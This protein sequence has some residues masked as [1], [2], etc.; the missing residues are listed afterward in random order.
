[1]ITSASLRLCVSE[2]LHFR[3]S[4][5][6]SHLSHHIISASLHLCVSAS[7]RL[8]ISA[9]LHRCIS[10]SLDH[11]G[12]ISG[13]LGLRVALRND[14]KRPKHYEMQR[15]ASAEPLLVRLLSLICAE[16]NWLHTPVPRTL[17]TFFRFWSFWQ[18]LGSL[19]VGPLFGMEG[20]QV[21]RSFQNLAVTP[22]HPEKRPAHTQA[23]LR[24]AKKR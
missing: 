20:K 14:A 2:S 21:A 24:R 22:G 7:P 17:P 4:T 11:V 10:A 1:M 19:G 9:S 3:I 16:N 23:T 18:V 13:P 6:V 12:S 15:A 5:C 8:C